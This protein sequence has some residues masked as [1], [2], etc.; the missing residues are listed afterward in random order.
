[1]N[2]N[3]PDEKGYFGR[4]GG[5]FIPEVLM[6]NVVELEKA[7]LFFKEDKKFNKELNTREDPLPYTSRKDLPKKQEE[8]RYT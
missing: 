7:Y 8:P 1:M 2:Y 5:R 4:F 6:N 3:L